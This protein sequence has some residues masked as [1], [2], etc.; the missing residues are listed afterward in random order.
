M[1]RH[2]LILD[3]YDYVGNKIC[4]LYD[5]ECDVSGQAYGVFISTER[6][7]WKELSFS[8]PDK[9]H[10]ENGEEDNYRIALLKSDYKIRS[11]DR[12]GADWFIITENKITHKSALKEVS[13]TAGH[14]SQMLKL[15]NLDLE[16][17]DAEGNNIGTAATLLG[18]VLEG[19]GWAPGE[20]SEFL[21]DDGTIKHRS[22]KASA[23]TGA[24]KLVTMVADLFEAKP[25]FHGDERTVD[26]VPMNPF[27]QEDKGVYP[28][29]QDPET[30]VE[31][32]Y[33]KNVNNVSRSVNTTNMIT[34]M[35]IYGSYG[36]TTYGYCSI[37][38]CVHSL[39]SMRVVEDALLSGERY[40][41]Q[42]EDDTGTTVVRNFIPEYTVYPGQHIIF[43]FL[44]PASMLYVWH[45]EAELLDS[46]DDPVYDSEGNQ[47]FGAPYICEEGPAGTQVTFELEQV[48][49]GEWQ[50][51]LEDYRT[52]AKTGSITMGNGEM[53]HWAFPDSD[54]EFVIDV[55]KMT[56]N[57]DEEEVW[58]LD[59]TY[60]GTNVRFDVGLRD[61]ELAYYIEVKYRA[62]LVNYEPGEI[63]DI[64]SRRDLITS[65]CKAMLGA[66]NW[67]NFLMDFGYYKK[68]GVLT[69]D[70][71]KLIAEYQMRA[72]EYYEKASDAS[73]K[74]SEDRGELIKN[75]G[76]IDFCRL[77]IA[78]VDPIPDKDEN[79]VER[80]KLRIDKSEDCPD[81][82]MY[83][84]DYY[85]T[86]KNNRFKYYGVPTLNEDG[87]PGSGI[88]SVL[89]I[90]HDTDPLTWD[91]IFLYNDRKE[92]AT[93]MMENPDFLVLHATP[94]KYHFDVL[95]DKFFLLKYLGTSGYL[96]A[97]E[98]VMEGAIGSLKEV[99]RDGTY[100]HPVFFG[101]D[102]PEDL[103]AEDKVIRTRIGDFLD[104]DE[105][106]GLNEF[107]GQEYSWYWMHH[108][109]YA[110]E[111]RMYF[112]YRIEGDV[113]DIT[114]S[115]GKPLGLYHYVHYQSNPPTDNIEERD[116]WYDFKR[117]KLYRY[118]NG[119]WTWLDTDA[120][121]RV[122]SRFGAV[123]QQCMRID[124]AYRGVKEKYVY[125]VPDENVLPRGNYY[126][127]NDFGSA[128]ILTTT[129]DLPSASTLTY[130]RKDNAIYQASGTSNLM[131]KSENVPLD[132]VYYHPDN[133]VSDVQ[134]DAGWI[135]NTGAI[136]D[137]VTD[138]CYT[139]STMYCYPN[140]E[141][142]I[143]GI[144]TLEYRIVEYS[145]TNGNK[146][147]LKYHDHQISDEDDG[148]F[149][150]D[151]RT[152]YIRLCIKATSDTVNATCVP[153]I[154]A[155]LKDSSFV[156]N[157]VNYV[158]LEGV[159]PQ[160]D[161][162][163]IIDAMKQFNTLADQVY[164]TD[165]NKLKSAQAEVDT[166]LLDMNEA[167][168]DIMREGYWQDSNYVDGDEAKL[169]KDALEKLR[170]A[171]RPELKYD[172]K[173]VDT[174]MA[175][176]AY[177]DTGVIDLTRDAPWPWIT[178]KTA[179]HLLDPDPDVDIDEWAYV[180]KINRCYD[181][182][183]K[184]TIA[185][186]TN[187]SPIT[188]HSFGD[189][190]ANIADVAYETR[191]TSTQGLMRL[192][193]GLTKTDGDSTMYQQYQAENSD[194]ISSTVASLQTTVSSIRENY[195][196]ATSLSSYSTIEQT[197]E[198]IASTVAAIQ[199]DI[200][201]G[202]N[203]IKQS[204]FFLFKTREDYASTVY[205]LDLA[206]EYTNNIF[207]NQYMTLSY[208][209]DTQGKRA[210][211]LDNNGQFDNYFGAGVVV[212]WGTR[213]TIGP[214]A[215]DDTV[216]Y[217]LF[218]MCQASVDG[219]RVAATAKIEPPSGYDTIRDIYVSVQLTA[220]PAI[221][222]D[223]TWTF[224]QPQLEIG[225][226]CTGYKESAFEIKE[227]AQAQIKQS[228]DEITA[229]VQR[230]TDEYDKY[231]KVTLSEDGL[232]TVV[233]STQTEDG[234]ASAVF[235]TEPYNHPVAQYAWSPLP[236]IEPK[237]EEWLSS[238]PSKTGG[239]VWTRNV[240][241]NNGTVV[242]VLNKQCV[243][244]SDIEGMPIINADDE[245]CYMR[246]LITYGT[247]T[248]NGKEH[249]GI[250]Y[251]YNGN[252]EWTINGT[253]TSTS[254]YSIRIQR[255][256]DENWINT[257][258]ILYCII[259]KDTTNDVSLWFQ[260][261]INSTKQ[262]KVT[263]KE[264]G[265]VTI[266]SGVNKLSI[267]ISVPKGKTF[268]NAKVRLCIMKKPGNNDQ[269]LDEY[270]GPNRDIEAWTRCK[271]LYGN[272][273]TVVTE[274][275]PLQKT[276]IKSVNTEFAISNSPDT[277]A[278][279]AIWSTKL[280]EGVINPN[281]YV[282]TRIKYIYK[283]N[284]VY[285]STPTRMVKST[286]NVEEP[287][288]LQIETFYYNSS[289]T[290]NLTVAEIDDFSLWSTNLEFERGKNMWSR[291]K[292]Y[293]DDG[294]ILWCEPQICTAYN[295][296]YKQDDLTITDV[297]IRY[298]KTDSNFMPPR[299]NAV[300]ASA[301]PQFSEGE[302]V[303]VS[304]WTWCKNG[305]LY[306]S[307]PEL[308]PDSYSDII[309]AKESW[310]TSSVGN[311]RPD[312][313][314]Y[315]SN[316]TWKPLEDDSYTEREESSDRFG[317]YA[318]KMWI[319]ISYKT[320][321]EKNKHVYVRVRYY[322]N[323][324]D[325]AIDLNKS[326]QELTSDRYVT[327][328][329]KVEYDDNGNTLSSGMS[330]MRQTAN[331]IYKYLMSD[332]DTAIEKFEAGAIYTAL[333]SSETGAIS[334]IRHKA[335][336]IT[337]AMGGISK[338]MIPKS[339]S[340]TIIEYARDDDS[341]KDYAAND[342]FIIDNSTYST[343]Y[344]HLQGGD[345]EDK[346][347]STTSQIFEEGVTVQTEEHIDSYD[348]KISYY[349]REDNE[350]NLMNINI[351][352]E[353]NGNVK[354]YIKPILLSHNDAGMARSAKIDKGA[355]IR[356]YYDGTNFVY[357]DVTLYV[358]EPTNEGSVMITIPYNDIKDKSLRISVLLRQYMGFRS[359]EAIKAN[360]KVSEIKYNI[361]KITK[362]AYEQTEYTLVDNK[363]LF[364]ENKI[365]SYSVSGL[366]KSSNSYGY[367][368]VYRKPKKDANYSEVERITIGSS[369]V[370][371]N[372]F[373]K[374]NILFGNN[375][376]LYKISETTSYYYKLTLCTY[377]NNKECDC[378]IRNV[379]IMTKRESSNQS[380][381]I[382][383]I[384]DGGQIQAGNTYKLIITS[385]NVVKGNN[386]NDVN[387][388]QIDI[389]TETGIVDGEVETH[390]DELYIPV[391]SDKG[392]LFNEDSDSQY[393]FEYL[394]ENAKGNGNIKVYAG[395]KNKTAGN[396]VY[397]NGVHIYKYPKYDETNRT[398]KCFIEGQ[399]ERGNYVTIGPYT[400][401][402]GK[403]IFSVMDI[404]NNEFTITKDIED[405]VISVK[406][407]GAG[408]ESS[409][410]TETPLMSYIRKTKVKCSVFD[411]IDN[412][413]IASVDFNVNISKEGNDFER[414]YFSFSPKKD[415]EFEVRLYPNDSEEGSRG[416]SI[417]YK[418]IQLEEAAINQ[419]GPT[420]WMVKTGEASGTLTNSALVIDDS[421]ISATGGNIDIQ[422]GTVFSVGSQ[423]IVKIASDSEDSSIVF[424]TTEKVTIGS[425]GTEVSDPVFSVNKN[426][427]LFAKR[428]SF[429][430][431]FVNG[432]ELS[433]D[434]IQTYIDSLVNQRIR[435]FFVRAN[436]AADLPPASMN[437]NGYFWLKPDTIEG[438]QDMKVDSL[439][440]LIDTT[441]E[442]PVKGINSSSILSCPISIPSACKKVQ[443][444]LSF[445][446]SNQTKHEEQY[447]YKSMFLRSITVYAKG[448]NPSGV[449]QT[450]I[451]QSKNFE[452]DEEE[453]KVP[454]GSV[455]NITVTSELT[456]N[457]C[458][459]GRCTFTIEATWGSEDH[460]PFNGYIYGTGHHAASQ[461]KPSCTFTVPPFKGETVSLGSVNSVS[462]KMYYIP[463]GF[464]V[465]VET[466]E[467]TEEE[468]GDE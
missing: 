227:F 374:F 273:S 133:I 440:V 250:V 381:N 109:E 468:G 434:T 254:S 139:K 455:L 229:M 120:E 194:G 150:T 346:I 123:H 349:G 268:N 360:L 54:A 36:D 98:S 46:N 223:S 461:G 321:K 427:G 8:L 232:I 157:G 430:S 309:N 219:R 5:S 15:K 405:N 130:S 351:P 158:K 317:V 52:W 47:M 191:T 245:Y 341:V 353:E 316:F 80:E 396:V 456:T 264:N 135:N 370:D 132:G 224:G 104:A 204:N 255:T 400:S 17:S 239:Y 410:I 376:E 94:G 336:E 311:V 420:D 199:K 198:A 261:Y 2:K 304:A 305:D 301:I 267:G 147:F 23:K 145:E 122:A 172:V 211:L 338:N 382:E 162:A 242:L 294:S 91:R 237:E 460:V 90:I 226:F 422:A 210:Q 7:G 249:N 86:N 154:H 155:V 228:S 323:M 190:L 66:K 246:N 322:D 361:L 77:R 6:N 27:T 347:Q 373:S 288:V 392:V 465:E 331:G 292:V 67:F 357:K 161:T 127:E 403:Y 358:N 394:I 178:T 167:L 136:D 293:Y 431:L 63:Q 435:E 306:R 418:Y 252:E 107:L 466:D 11:E 68:N 447:K 429:S 354:I 51:A 84:T 128:W 257:G 173:Y 344:K 108:P 101:T 404:K 175:D 124:S 425:D 414:Q 402:G 222:N 111:S 253:S 413:Y 144:G 142:R 196:Q 441:N 25:V 326:I 28:E 20:V 285:T 298:A 426:D 459:G 207:I 266:P 300:W 393:V 4:P 296:L 269:W 389:T 423:G 284:S 417:T 118:E 19:T 129:K 29:I 103:P 110:E 339:I 433:M 314:D 342:A 202:A 251:T 197:A 372:G 73:F 180:D 302:Y 171:A 233:Q 380:Y 449:E 121:K 30:V 258:D 259:D 79:G 41:F 283:D 408:T 271:I 26:L 256:L 9:V 195:V 421:G 415:D 390:T 112:C 238:V 152:T 16:F 176:M 44:D 387:R 168:G 279:N 221:D 275:A 328:L 218:N 299:D 462:Y 287:K 454:T 153:N 100:E 105:A 96:G 206:E 125:T 236:T 278:N 85:V 69:D 159:E 388:I 214:N 74:M 93:G 371:E 148:V 445:G 21:E 244:Q 241:M 443:Y 348:E 88:A 444:S 262:T 179:V 49:S 45:P 33:G 55:Y 114:G 312:D 166:M 367:I 263:L 291:S 140:V 151:N 78:G 83:R 57:D 424:G 170:A 277:I 42:V 270:L 209:L 97:Y 240:I 53:H 70:M 451:V 383:L 397:L 282:W 378:E 337:L 71:I 48:E 126:M 188:Q 265:E 281:E 325:G 401:N 208:F 334:E 419:D 59:K 333:T 134:F 350:Y 313:P 113:C 75:I 411:K 102:Y 446:F 379:D 138:S 359:H 436:K 192:L 276:K 368:I 395:E 213:E 260:T 39:R 335:D 437:Y 18:R 464:G 165:H 234:D 307:I 10:T 467:E 38:E 356:I 12:D 95:N 303:W 308:M 384:S 177:E 324:V 185:I 297:E 61:K 407:L 391:T 409:L 289:N 34:K 187:L 40:Y 453:Q 35:H 318:K 31:L 450:I 87:Y 201:G 60:T 369:S 295:A 399:A 184:T 64:I 457:V 116:Y 131:I 355:Q 203:L 117:T 3:L 330:E 56:Q 186:N 310:A 438:L 442:I 247:N 183:L 1:K 143:S 363:K 50:S 22:L 82:V 364:S 290:D 119:E 272:G 365:I 182:P 230:I 205:R 439:Q 386:N 385:G 319:R 362:I 320:A 452:K 13:V 62:S 428:A 343:V 89:Y 366:I 146:R 327:A 231:A 280:R 332:K 406:S 149:T 412:T 215:R 377:E 329:M 174:S 200:S 375:E 352:K 217:Y 458:C 160:G 164:I 243:D 345:G 286:A 225:K 137:T 32:H 115:D 315:E 248:I 340:R 65:T 220:R 37:D 212:I 14:V 181:E 163:G 274:A 416:G 216:K 432:V 193:E 156:V 99:T 106:L 76:A 43:S 24:F 463:A 141:Y 235:D 58:K 169:Y 189:V 72:P 448:I 92:N 81:G 398:D